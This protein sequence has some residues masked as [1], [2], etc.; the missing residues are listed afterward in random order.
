MINRKKLVI[1]MTIALFFTISS[2]NKDNHKEITDPP[3]EAKLMTYL[4]SMLA[5]VGANSYSDVLTGKLNGNFEFFA[6]YGPYITTC[7]NPFI[8][9]TELNGSVATDSTRTIAVNAGMLHINN[10]IVN[11]D[12]NL[13]YQIHYG[14]PNYETQLQELNT[15]YGKTNNIKLVKDGVDIFNKNVYIPTNIVM[16]GYNCNTLIMQGDPMQAGNIIK[17]NADY[18][19]T[20]G[21]VVEFNGV[22][23]TGIER[24]TYK[25]V[26]DNGQYSIT[27]SDLNIYPKSENDLGVEITLIRGNFFFTKGTDGRTYNFT[28]ATY[29]GYPFNIK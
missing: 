24:Y 11:P 17:W 14:T 16:K 15:I 5:S 26:P 10:L 4:D 18:K 12:D 13:R 1:I 3:T 2:C 9:N 19:N 27:E 28:V 23:N 8:V 20:N 22:D 29:C 7:S 25:L 21:V 6:H